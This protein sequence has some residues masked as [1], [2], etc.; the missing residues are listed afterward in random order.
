MTSW[1]GSSDVQPDGRIVTAGEGDP[2]SVFRHLA[3]GD[4]SG[5]VETLRAAEDA[6]VRDGSHAGTNFGDAAQLQVKKGDVGW[7]RDAY[8]RF[9]LSSRAVDRLGDAASCSAGST[10][11][12]APAPRFTAVQRVEH[13]VGARPASRG[14]TSPRPARPCAG[15]GTVTGTTGAWYELDLTSFLAGREGG[16]AERWSRSCCGRRPPARRRSC[17]TATRR[18]NEPQVVVVADGTRPAPA[19]GPGRRR[20][21]ACRCPEG[22]NAAFTVKLAAQPAADVVVTVAKA[23][24]GDGGPDDHDRVADVFT[25]TNWDVAQQVTVAAAED[26]DTTNGAATFTVSSR[27]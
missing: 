18:T 14:T 21:R 24:G 20:P 16:R 23:S 2:V 15:H 13:D 12:Q 9:D 7:N 17:S 22:G 4:D 3:E 25:P 5:T 27:G 6:Y 26:A 10:T 11:P 1:P 8:L 19:A